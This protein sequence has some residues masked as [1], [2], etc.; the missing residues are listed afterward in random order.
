MIKISVAQQEKDTVTTD[1][2]N[3]E[4]DAGQSTVGG[5]SVV[6]SDAIVHHLVPIFTGKDLERTNLRTLISIHDFKLGS[7]FYQN[8]MHLHLIQNG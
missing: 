1:E 6:S 7:H 4:I 2:E 8:V 3:D 5:D